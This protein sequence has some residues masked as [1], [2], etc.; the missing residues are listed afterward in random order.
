MYVFSLCFLLYTLF[1]NGFRL[2]LREKHDALRVA[3]NANIYTTPSQLG[4][5]PSLAL[6]DSSSLET[7]YLSA[8]DMLRMITDVVSPSAKLNI[9]G[10]FVTLSCRCNHVTE[11]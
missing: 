5:S 4:L 1:Y 9:I 2:Y 6:L 8:I 3:M 7:P 11:L 10:V